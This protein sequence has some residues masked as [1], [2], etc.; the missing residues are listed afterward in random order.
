MNKVVPAISDAVS[1]VLVEALA[2]AGDQLGALVD[3]EIAFRGSHLDCVPLEEL[4]QHIEAG[5]ES[6]VTAVYIA[7]S[8]GIDGHVVL[9]FTPMAAAYL[10]R[11][12]L[13]ND[14]DLDAPAMRYLADSMLGELGNVAASSF[15]N[16]VAAAAGITVLPSPPCVVHDMW[17]AVL[18][19]VVVEVAEEQSFGL[20][21]HTDFIIDGDPFAG[22]LVLLPSLA[23]CDRLERSIA[24]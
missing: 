5:P 20:L 18:Q 14:G 3:R 19:S 7:F 4:P 1:A 13:M 21:L 17:G 8:G 22:N 2:Q 15:L 12:L 6:P 11:T 16:A 23:S 24:R 10:A 9:S